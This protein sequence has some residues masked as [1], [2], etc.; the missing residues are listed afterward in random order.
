MRLISATASPLG[1][2]VGVP[3]LRPVPRGREDD[4][5]AAIYEFETTGTW[6]KRAAGDDLSISRH[7][8]ATLALLPDVVEV[9]AIDAEVDALNEWLERER[10][11]CVF[12]MTISG[13]TAPRL[14]GVGASGDEQANLRLFIMLRGAGSDDDARSRLQAARQ[15][16]LDAHDVDLEAP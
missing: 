11:D 16:L 8:A 4:Q 2:T 15:W 5:P 13:A 9:Q 10:A 3:T 6:F 12:V 1:A 7:V 14:S